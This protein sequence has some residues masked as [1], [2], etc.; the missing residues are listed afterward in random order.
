[1]NNLINGCLNI[2]TV[3]LCPIRLWVPMEKDPFAQSPALN[4][5]KKT[6]PTSLVSICLWY[7]AW[8]SHH[9]WWI[10]LTSPMLLGGVMSPLIC[11]WSG[12]VRHIETEPNQEAP[13]EKEPETLVREVVLQT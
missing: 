3:V 10:V 9:A 6:L 4:L 5:L 2:L 1:M 12:K 8:R 13:V 11:W 7:L